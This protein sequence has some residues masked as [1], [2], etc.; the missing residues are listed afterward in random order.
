M[1]PSYGLACATMAGIPSE[2]VQRAKVVS[3]KLAKNQVVE[4]LDNEVMKDKEEHYAQ[5][6][7]KFKQLVSNDFTEQDVQA[8]MQQL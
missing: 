2:I 3:N 7:D 5:V 6:V 8:F 4:R 1:T